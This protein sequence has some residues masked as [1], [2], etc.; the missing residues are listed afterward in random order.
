MA[1]YT[2]LDVRPLLGGGQLLKKTSFS[3]SQQLSAANSFVGSNQVWLLAHLP[4]RA[5][6]LSGLTCADLMHA[7]T[8]AESAY[9]QL[10]AVLENRFLM[11]STVSGS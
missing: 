7:V 8:T 4:L 10:P 5:G 1:A 6:I 2:L 3:P 9:V 11:L